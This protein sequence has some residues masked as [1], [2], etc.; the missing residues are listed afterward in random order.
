MPM[1]ASHTRDYHMSLG[2]KVFS[3]PV[4]LWMNWPLWGGLLAILLLS[5]HAWVLFALD[6]RPSPNS[7]VVTQ[8][9][10]VEQLF[11]VVNSVSVSA[12]LNGI[13]PI[14]IFASRKNGFAVMQTENGQVGVGLGGFVAPG[15]LLIETHPDYVI[16]ERNGIQ[17]RVD[18]SKESIAAGGVTQIQGITPAQDASFHAVPEQNFDQF[19]QE[20]RKILQQ[21]HQELLRGMH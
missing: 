10:Q 15:I 7:T 20:Q 11:G 12:S 6:E 8:S 3:A 14:G 13:R 19:T 2:K 5:K 17:Q 4:R 9:T 16:L 21:Q 1:F 18:L